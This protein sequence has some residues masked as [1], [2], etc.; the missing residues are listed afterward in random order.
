MPTAISFVVIYEGGT[1]VEDAMV[2]GEQHLP[3]LQI[4]LDA[5]AILMDHLLHYFKGVDLVRIQ[6]FSCTVLPH[7]DVIVHITGAQIAV[8]AGKDGKRQGRRFIG[9]VLSA[10]IELK[11]LIESLQRVGELV[12]DSVVY[13]IRAHQL[14]AP[15]VARGL[16][17]QQTDDLWDSRIECTVGVETTLG[18]GNR[19]PGPAAD[20]LTG[21]ADIK[22]QCAANILN[23]WFAD[24]MP[25]GP[26]H[27]REP[28][29][30]ALFDGEPVHDC[31][32]SP[33]S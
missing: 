30:R 16:Q 21:G 5:H 13:R 17:T 8:A 9:L 14:T 23:L 12:G 6:G 33:I 10:S 20:I 4:E 18:V 15:T 19:E 31:E 11:R 3:R 26:I 32:T 2:A 29:L 22:Q 1:V 24:E 25:E 27:S 28:L 7:L